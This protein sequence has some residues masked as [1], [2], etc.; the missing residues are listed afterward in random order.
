[1][2][3]SK[4]II[5]MIPI[6]FFF[7]FFVSSSAINA[8]PKN[9]PTTA[10]TIC[11]STPY[12]SDCI[13]NL[14]P[15][16]KLGSVR[17]F[18]I[19]FLHKS[20]TTTEHFLSLLNTYLNRRRPG[21]LLTTLLS[22]PVIRALQDCHLLAELSLD[23]LSKTYQTLN[24]THSLNSLE[25]AEEFHTFLSAVLTNTQT[26]LEGLHEVG[27]SP[28]T[29]TRVLSIPLSVGTK[30]YSISLALFK[31]GWVDDVK[32]NQPAKAIVR[33]G[34]GR[35]L[36]Q[37]GLGGGVGGVLVGGTVVVNQ[38]GTGNF[39]T[40]NEAVAAAPNRTAN[41]N[42]TSYFVIYVA[43]GVYEEYVSIPRNKRNLMLI[44]DGIDRT[45]I[46]G[47]RSVVDGWTTYNSATF[48]VAGQ[49]FVAI[50]ITFRNTAG[51]I[52]HQA[53][54]VRN[55]ADLS[56]FYSCSFEGYQDTL[57]AH[58]LRQ[59]YR[60]CDIYGTIDFIF[61]NAAVV[62]QNCNIYPRQ[63]LP[64]QF[65]A[66][67]AQGRSDPNQNTGTSIQ[68]CNIRA[69]QDLFTAN[70]NTNSSM[71]TRTF[72]GRPWKEYSTTVFMQSYMD[73]LIDPAGWSEWSGNFSLNTLYYAEF[74]NTGP[75][76]NTSSRVTWPG[77]HVLSTSLDVANFTLSSFIMGDSW[78]PTTGVP[79]T[80]GL[81]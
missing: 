70:T 55:G 49:G 41:S 31:H 73:N 50:N 69:A 77:Y 37:V 32:Y 15:P 57:Y 9:S 17:D 59:F 29:L 44:G 19:H 74:N 62:L 65:N 7:F 36:P 34:R 66:I 27:N 1:M 81:L 3:N 28:P 20:L 35:R 2:A 18:C 16:Q 79:Y 25:L 10:E 63:P 5:L 33:G 43:G 80:N 13:S 38:N 4:P 40:I 6:L 23:T 67:T 68:N 54:A 8:T 14:P 47:N 71:R 39:S 61:G 58:S 30:L 21:G 46:T 53:V 78:L 12:P 22:Q 51:A 26:C 24:F 76:S 48:A 52:K 75:G 64:R 56:A 11:N 72:L 42:I 45:V 60:D